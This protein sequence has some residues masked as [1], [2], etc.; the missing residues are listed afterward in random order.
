MPT[1][2]YKTRE[3]AEAAA[4]GVPGAYIAWDRNLQMWMVIR[5]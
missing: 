2:H 4:A 5:P 1:E 3:E